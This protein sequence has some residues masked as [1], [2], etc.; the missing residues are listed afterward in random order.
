MKWNAKRCKTKFFIK[1]KFL[2][3]KEVLVDIFC[4]VSSNELFA[5]VI[6]GTCA[7]YTSTT[8]KSG[9]LQA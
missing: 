1:A 7:I 3:A 8:I 4:K 2:K 9:T 6:K 5:P